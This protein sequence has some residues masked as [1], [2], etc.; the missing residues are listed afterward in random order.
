MHWHTPEPIAWCLVAVACAFLLSV[1]WTLAVIVAAIAK[2]R[3]DLSHLQTVEG[4]RTSDRLK[5][6]GK[7][8][9]RL[10]LAMVAGAI[11]LM[12][13]GAIMETMKK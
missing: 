1:V 10:W 4:R 9:F 7:I 13:V 12:I 2:S 11:L 3:C 8:S 5:G 6:I